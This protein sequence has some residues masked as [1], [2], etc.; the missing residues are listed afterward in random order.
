MLTEAT[1]YKALLAVALLGGVVLWIH[2]SGYEA[3]VADTKEQLGKAD[4]AN[5]TC[6][7]ALAD[8]KLSLAQCETNRLVDQNAQLKASAERD[9][10]QLASDKAFDALAQQLH[11]KL[12]HECADWAAQ[13]A[14]GSI[15]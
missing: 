11:W 8:Q 9:K 10:Q 3:G 7:G 1:I 15:P 6:V 13:P 14:C 2:H 12:T 4:D 5:R